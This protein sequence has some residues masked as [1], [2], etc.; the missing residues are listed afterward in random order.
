MYD[1]I[2]SLTSSVQHH[3]SISL[4]LPITPFLKTK[5]SMKR[6]NAIVIVMLKS[7]LNFSGSSFPFAA[8]Q[9]AQGLN[10]NAGA[11]QFPSFGGG[12]SFTLGAAN[13]TKTTTANRARRKPLRR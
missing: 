12:G 10:F 6:S 8:T 4:L 7:Y 1:E 9:P 3:S 11:S 5:V 13:A 2:I